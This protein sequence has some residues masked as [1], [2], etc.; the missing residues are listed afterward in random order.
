MRKQ[1]N[2]YLKKKFLFLIVSSIFIFLILPQISATAQFYNIPDQKMEYSN[3]KILPLSLYCSSTIQGNSC[4]DT[5]YGLEFTNPSTGQTVFLFP[6]QSNNNPYF[7]ISLSSDGIVTINSKS[8]TINTNIIVYGA[9]IPYSSQSSKSFLLSIK[10]NQKPVQI[11]SFAPPTLIN[12]ETAFYNLDN[13]FID[14]TGI[15]VNFNDDTFAQ[16][17]NLQTSLTQGKVCSDGQLLVCL[18]VSSNDYITLSI[19]GK[20]QGYNTTVTGGNIFSISAINSFGETSAF[21]MPVIV[22][23]E[24]SVTYTKIP[25]RAPLS[26]AGINLNYNQTS[27]TDLKI[28]YS[29]YTSLNVTYKFTGSTVH[30]LIQNQTGG[31][32]CSG[33][34]CQ[35]SVSLGSVD[36]SVDDSPFPSTAS[37]TLILFPSG[38]LQVRSYISDLSNYQ[39][40]LSAC[41]SV[42]C[43]SSD[44]FG[45]PDIIF[46]NIIGISPSAVPITL[47]PI[48][49]NYAEKKTLNLNGVFENFD[50][51]NVQWNESLTEFN[52]SSPVTGYNATTYTSGG[53]PVYQVKLYFNSILE[54][55]SANID[56]SN[57]LYLSACNTISCVYGSNGINQSIF[58]EI[59]DIP[60][61]GG[62]SNMDIPNT[63]LNNIYNTFEGLF[64]SKETLSSTQRINIIII[65]L[66][67]LSISIIFFAYQ[68]GSNIIPSIYMAGI[69]SFFTFL[70][71]IAKGYSS[72]IVL[73]VIGVLSLGGIYFKFKGG[74]E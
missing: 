41:N 32:L 2:L 31:F 8:L 72:P 42:G 61:E 10:E 23:I 53:L 62:F 49:L 26:I 11:A 33:T 60:V 59:D 15:R 51:T 36:G 21:Q 55:S 65:T 54:I 73:V 20:N 29:N 17:V 39:I 68:S 18:T 38:I 50:Y 7:T 35:D 74:A 63:G 45:N 67:T 40:N 52:L 37:I 30:S 13:F 1:T 57:T 34:S 3:T 9:D 48:H 47:A 44:D 71:F 14:Y 24:T 69:V 66:F 70:Y 5:S 58:F 19:Q 46:L 27:V 22:K 43:I 4:S 28:F 12:N 16:T 6:S 64:P 56:H 25:I